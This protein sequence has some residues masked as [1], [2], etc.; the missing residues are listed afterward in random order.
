MQAYKG[1]RGLFFDLLFSNFLYPCKPMLLY[2]STFLTVL[3]A[4]ERFHAV[5]H[6][7]EYRNAT[8]TGRTWRLAL[9]HT[10]LCMLASALFV[11]PLIFESEVLT[12]EMRAVKTWNSTHTLE[13]SCDLN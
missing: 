4:R 7:I 11:I 13:V 9:I 8:L 12:K 10:A 6:P 3:M 1:I 2:T 5:K